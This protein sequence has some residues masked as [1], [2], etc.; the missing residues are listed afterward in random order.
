MTRRD[1]RSEVR[2]AGGFYHWWNRWLVRFAGPPQVGPYET[3]PPPPVAQVCPVCGAPLAAHEIDRTG[4][5]TFM[6]CPAA[7]ARA[8]AST[9]QGTAA[10]PEEPA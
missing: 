10:P 5:R 3:T 7:P 4:A 8:V 6:R 1:L 9:E 2:D